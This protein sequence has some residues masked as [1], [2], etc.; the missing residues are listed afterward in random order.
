[1]VVVCSD[2]HV[3]CWHVTIHKY[4]KLFD[5]LRYC[6]GCMN[7]V[8]GDV[9]DSIITMCV[10]TWD[11][12]TCNLYCCENVFFLIISLTVWAWWSHWQLLHKLSPQR[13]QLW[14]QQEVLEPVWKPWKVW[15]CVCVCVSVSVCL[16]VYVVL[17]Y[18]VFVHLMSS[19]ADT[20]V[21]SKDGVTTH[22][23]T[24][25]ILEPVQD[26]RYEIM[27]LQH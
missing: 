26:H 2:T 22:I 12:S 24:F 23:R 18:V 1:M 19:R 15:V 20:Y 11:I 10:W 6:C 5:S 14:Q 16:C 7:M 8:E 27:T 13:K 21:P 4:R 25:L 3:R 17:C 9:S